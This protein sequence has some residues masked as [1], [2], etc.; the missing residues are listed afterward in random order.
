[1]AKFGITEIVPVI[2]V[3][4]YATCELVITPYHIKFPPTAVMENKN[5]ST[6]L[7]LELLAHREEDTVRTGFPYD[8]KI[9]T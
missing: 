9:F 6:L 4:S 5:N 7:S 2:E 3:S 8:C 1:M